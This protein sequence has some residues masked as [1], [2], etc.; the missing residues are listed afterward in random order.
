M[1]S[2][3]TG[4]ACACAAALDAAAS[5][6]SPGTES[7]DAR[8]DLG[9]LLGDASLLRVVDAPDRAVSVPRTNERVSKPGARRVGLPGMFSRR[10][11]RDAPDDARG[12]G[13]STSRAALHARLARARLADDAPDQAGMCLRRLPIAL[14]GDRL[15]RRLHDPA[16][17]A[18][19]CRA[20]ALAADAWRTAALANPARFAATKGAEK[21]ARDGEAALAALAN[22]A[23]RCVGRANQL[24]PMIGRP[25]SGR[26]G[27]RTE[28]RNGTRRAARRERARA[29]RSVRSWRRRRAR[30]RRCGPRSSRRARDPRTST[31]RKRTSRDPSS[32]TTRR[33]TIGPRDSSRN[34]RSPTCFSTAA[35][36]T[37]DANA[38]PIS[39]PRWR[40]G[41]RPRART[42]VSG[43]AGPTRRGFIFAP[44]AS[45]PR[46]GRGGGRGRRIRRETTIAMRRTWGR[47][48]V[49]DRVRS[50]GVE[51]LARRRVRRRAGRGVDARRGGISSERGGARRRAARLRGRG[52]RGRV[53]ARRRR[54]S[55][56]RARV[57][58]LPSR[59]RRGGDDDRRGV[60]D[61]RRRGIRACDGRARRR[62]RGNRALA[63]RVHREGADTP[64]GGD[65]TGRARRARAPRARARVRVG[66]ATRRERTSDGLGP[67]GLGPDGL[68]P[69]GGPDGGPDLTDLIITVGETVAAAVES[70]TYLREM[71]RAVVSAASRRWDAANA[72]NV[73]GDSSAS[74][75]VAVATR[76]LAAS[77]IGILE[78]LLGDDPKDPTWSTRESATLDAL[79]DALRLGGDASPS[80]ASISY[81]ARAFVVDALLPGFLARETRDASQ[82][83][84]ARTWTSALGLCRRLLKAEE[85]GVEGDDA[86]RLVSRTLAAPSAAMLDAVVGVGEMNHHAAAAVA[87]LFD[88]LAEQMERAVG[89]SGV[90][91]VSGRTDR[92][93]PAAPEAERSAPTSAVAAPPERSAPAVAAPR[94]RSAPA[95]AARASDRRPRRSPAR[96]PLRFRFRSRDT[97]RR[98]PRKSAGIFP[99]PARPPRGPPRGPPRDPP[100]DPPRDPRGARRS[101]R[102]L[103]RNTRRRTNAAVL[104]RLAPPPPR[105]SRRPPRRLLR[106]SVAA[107]VASVAAAALAA[108]G[109]RLL[110]RRV[111]L[112]GSFER[113]RRARDR[114]VA[115]HR[116]T[117]L[118]TLDRARATVASEARESARF[119]GGAGGAS[120]PLPPG[121]VVRGGDGDAVGVSAV[122]AQGIPPRGGGVDETE[123]ETRG[124]IRR[125]GSSPSRGATRG[126]GGGRRRVARRRVRR[127]DA[128]RGGVAP[129]T[130][131]GGVRAGYR[132]ARRR[133]AGDA[134][135]DD[136][137]T[138]EAGHGR[139]RKSR[140]RRE[141]RQRGS[142]VGRAR[143]RTSTQRAR[144][145]TR[146]TSAGRTRRS[147]RVR[148][149]STVTQRLA[150]CR[151]RLSRSVAH[152]GNVVGMTR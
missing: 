116:A 131:G 23:A 150:R 18:S 40:C 106:A 92:A 109:R 128:S 19:V 11:G 103:R 141:H 52:R 104:T 98:R 17:R 49:D 96:R 112:F 77:T 94:E 87:T 139:A 93:V 74:S 31:P 119:D 121:A 16:P 26:V 138:P 25:S 142:G 30:R 126:A 122:R 36:P 9:R 43:G 130:R 133:V 46:R 2:S 89:S 33:R 70:G 8:R 111:F 47:R 86:E 152:R 53:S 42:P 127:G 37:S 56:S 123:G 45:R 137:V 67:D 14:G 80:S 24:K 102:A 63:R 146:R 62:R 79:A 84:C 134:G 66:C 129:R 73:A 3:R 151:G 118:A 108:P 39:R 57:R 78:S 51:R 35:R 145:R 21:L 59:R 69:H 125:G 4:R 75:R 65:R 38:R 1:T 91:G 85:G 55:A 72:A 12:G 97:R 58:R 90:S 115:R 13:R 117:L 88:I 120:A 113:R 34:A 140:R 5:L 44:R 82:T 32:W 54:V 101:A 22:E 7:R 27:E 143:R 135:G 60:D 28:S 15:P 105:L 61:D 99:S 107:A 83:R 132:D 147:G 100:S 114:Q 71:I 41:R 20:V 6:V 124:G 10:R 136:E 144:T 48:D 110:G 76:D 64:P 95:V 148:V 29:A 50:G 149:R 81:S 68:G